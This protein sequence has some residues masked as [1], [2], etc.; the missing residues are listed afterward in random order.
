MAEKGYFN[1]TTRMISK[2]ANIAIGTIYTNFKSKEDILDHIFETEYNK[3]AAYLNSLET[4]SCS[5][6]EKFHFFL[7]FHFNELSKN[8]CLTTVL[9]RESTNPELQHLKGVEKFIYQLPHFFKIIL[10]K[11]LDAGEIRQL[12]SSVT[13]EIIFNTIRGT[14]FSIALKNDKYDFEEIKQE[15]KDFITYAIK[16]I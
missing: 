11:A 8:E 6:I 4:V 1:T 15:L 13:A 14:V 9:I 10:E 2:K 3:R 12:N 16:K 5:H 7:D